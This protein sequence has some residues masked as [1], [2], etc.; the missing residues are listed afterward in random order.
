MNYYEKYL[1]QIKNVGYPQFDRYI[2]LYYSKDDNYTRRILDDSLELKSK[3]NKT[4]IKLVFGKTINLYKEKDKNIDKK[5]LLIYELNNLLMYSDI[6][7]SSKDI[8]IFEDI[9]EKLIKNNE[10]Y[11]NLNKIFDDFDKLKKQ[12][13]LQLSN[14]KH[15]LY[16][17]FKKRKKYYS[18]V[19]ELDSIVFLKIKKIFLNEKNIDNIKI[20]SLSKNIN[21]DEKS[22]KCILNWFLISKKYIKLQNTIDEESLNNKNRIEYISNIFYN[23][24]IQDPLVSISGDK[25]IKVKKPTSKDI[26]ISHITE[27]EKEE[28]L[29]PMEM[30]DEDKL[31][32][33]EELKN[34]DA[35]EEEIEEGETTDTDAEDENEE[36]EGEMAVEDLEESEG[37]DIIEPGDETNVKIEE[38]EEDDSSENESDEEEQEE[39]IAVDDKKG[40]DI[41]HVNISKES[42]KDISIDNLN[43]II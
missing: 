11:E 16:I 6:S 12:L 39:E 17:L 34:S 38:Q 29:K 40:G 21:L 5:K 27:N 31:I 8:K 25:I 18:Y 7:L 14:L 22:I 3:D 10:E 9:K 2:Q 23:F 33:K 35:S 24:Y 41:K 13:N 37:E 30:S 19:S 26:N 20:K 43:L 15:E 1:K 42:I 4:T 32:A 36:E 28:L